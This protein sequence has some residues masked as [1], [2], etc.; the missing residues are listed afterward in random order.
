MEN[1]I[2]F[3]GKAL[4]K[5]RES[6]KKKVKSSLFHHLRSL[7]FHAPFLH[8]P[9]DDDVKNRKSS[10]TRSMLSHKKIRKCR[11]ASCRPEVYPVFPKHHPDFFR[12]DK[13]RG[14]ISGTFLEF[15]RKSVQSSRT[16]SR[17]QQCWQQAALLLPH[18]AQGFRG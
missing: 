8:I 1:G 12:V 4:R 14:E 5:Y 6:I 2:Q 18:C 11:K 10:S 3:H 16:P 9:L 7:L 13:L 17:T 15:L